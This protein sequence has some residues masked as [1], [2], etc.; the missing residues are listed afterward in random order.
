MANKQ[1]LNNFV[2]DQEHYDDVPDTWMK[3][4]LRGDFKKAWQF[5]DKAMAEGVNRDINLP[6]HFQNIWDGTPLNGKRVLVRCYH[7]LGDTIQFIRYVPKLRQIAK[8]VIVWAQPALLDLL[9][10]VNGIDRLI[11]LHDGA[12]DVEYDVDIEVMELPYIFRS[13]IET[14]P[15]EVP[16]LQVSPTILANNSHL[17]VGIVW[18]A[19]NWNPGRCLPFSAVKP[20][21]D[22]HD[23][24]FY[25]L[26]DDA[27][28]AGWDKSSGVHPGS[29]NLYDYARVISGLDLLI[30]VDSMPAHLAG[31]LNVPVWTLLHADPDW[32]WMSNG[33]YSP[34]YP[35]MRLFRQQEQGN[36]SS[37]VDRV[38]FELSKL[39]H[40]SAIRP[41][42]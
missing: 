10:S 26:Q 15:S 23:V 42:A 4:M 38:S 21:L 12:P 30:T 36:W 11:P 33:D 24:N 29:F 9:K 17:S 6:R 13:T 19:G 18:R 32:R 34:W 39:V 5:S 22:R 8:E 31:A 16:Y 2:A 27:V 1:H 40:A 20:L 25:I 41:V 3:C 37:V 35:S 14:L 7:G 28:N